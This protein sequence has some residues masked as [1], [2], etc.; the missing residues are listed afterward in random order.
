VLYS[1]GITVTEFSI[2]RVNFSDHLPLICDF[3]ITGQS[4]RAARHFTQELSA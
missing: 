2:P 3:E 4:H 1:E